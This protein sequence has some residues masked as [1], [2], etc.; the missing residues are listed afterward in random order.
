MKQKQ[1]E[2]S[3]LLTFDPNYAREFLLFLN[4]KILIITVGK[5]A[6]TQVEL[7]TGT[8]SHFMQYIRPNGGP[9]SG[10]HVD[11]SSLIVFPNTHSANKL[12]EKIYC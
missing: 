11:P 10:N 1:R 5:I 3:S 2:K 12:K 7:L 4:T 9:K 6:M 8:H